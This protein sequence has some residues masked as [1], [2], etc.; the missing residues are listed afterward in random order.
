MTSEQIAYPINGDKEQLEPLSMINIKGIGKKVILLANQVLE[1]L[2]NV[3]RINKNINY[4]L[5]YSNFSFD[6]W[7]ILH[8]NQQKC[9]ISHRKQYVNGINKEYNERFHIN[10]YKE[11]KKLKKNIV[12]NKFR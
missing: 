4:K 9:S 6:L 10:D 1:D 5:G 12:K 2:K 3:K 8:K 7:I 11:E